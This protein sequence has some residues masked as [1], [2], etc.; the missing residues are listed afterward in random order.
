M[1]IDLMCS[2]V[3]AYIYKMKGV[4]VR[5]DRRAVAYDGR[6]M[7]MLMNAYQIAVNGDKEYGNI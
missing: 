4:Q 1:Q 3:E 7:A 5:I 6:Q 2:M